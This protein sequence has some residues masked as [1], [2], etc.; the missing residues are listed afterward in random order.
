MRKIIL[1][2]MILTVAFTLFGAWSNDASINTAISTLDAEQV[3][4][5]IEYG[6][7][8]TFYV[9][10]FVLVDGQY[11]VYL[12]HLDAS[13]DILWETTGLEISSH[14]SM[15][16]LTD[17]DMTVDN[18][19]NAILAFQ[20]IR[21]TNNDIFVYKIS[22]SG[23]FLWGADG[24]EL[25]QDGF[26]AAPKVTVL[27]NNNIVV[28]WMGEGWASFQCLSQDGTLLTG[29]NEVMLED[30][31]GEIS[32]SWPQI[33]AV[34]DGNFILKYYQDSGVSW[35][36]TRHVYAQKYNS[37][38]EALWDAPTVITNAGGISSWTQ[39]LSMVKD[40]DNGFYIT[41]YDDRDMDN[42]SEAFV[43]HV[44][45]EGLVSFTNGLSLSNQNT[46][47]HFNP[48]L[49]YDSEND[50]LY[51]NWVITDMD[52][53]EGG[54]QGQK[55]QNDELQWGDDGENILPLLT[56][57]TIL[58]GI[59]FNDDE[60]IT[61][62]ERSNNGNTSY[63]YS[64][65]FDIDGNSLWDTDV[66]MKS[67][68]GCIVHADL[69]MDD[70]NQIVA[71]WENDTEI[72]RIMAQNINWNGELGIPTQES[73]INGTVSL[74]NEAYN[75]EDVTITIGDDEYS[76]NTD[77]SF[78]IT[79]VAGTYTVIFSHEY[80]ESVE[81]EVT[82]I[83]GEYTGLTIE[84]TNEL[85]AGFAG[86]V[87]LSSSD[88]DVVD[89]LISIEELTSSPDSNG[90]YSIEYMPGTY[91]VSFSHPNYETVTLSVTITIGEVTILNVFMEDAVSN[92]IPELPLILEVYPNPLLVS[93]AKSI[94]TTINFTNNE[95]SNVSLQIYN[96]KG[97]LVKT[98]ANEYFTKGNHTLVWNGY[99]SKSQSVAAGIYFLQLNSKSMNE[100]KKITV[101]K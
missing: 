18:D 39:V 46:L 84:L 9:G 53:D 54:I 42:H 91:D 87:T 55:L 4:P 71:A 82:I 67:S 40:A 69:V 17:W 86:N 65:K 6:P 21:N 64:T 7:D 19:N 83:E 88:Y 47:L 1:T 32:Y 27:S 44:S 93:E 41:W 14:E 97:Q 8:G 101:L 2:I 52:Q 60:L 10:F 94:G 22:N 37:S 51:I 34:E 35:A 72:T 98:L 68:A 58:S 13:G 11:N 63:L 36:P 38:G 43:Q 48:N 31:Q 45:S 3:I 50:A 90:D 81:E 100:M 78:S 59:F 62:Y 49:A 96:I 33:L 25:S 79:Y 56:G 23:E 76:P 95:P 80:Y 66:V 73:G 29:D 89:V 75:V 57:S 74:S 16:W 20:D 15:S 85:V 99:N 77:G 61:V 30:P 28:S 24:I 12:Q 5:K 26:N 70:N 92:E